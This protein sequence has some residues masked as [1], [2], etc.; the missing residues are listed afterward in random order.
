[1]QRVLPIEI[2]NC[3]FFSGMMMKKQ[4]INVF[5]TIKY[6]QA[7][8]IYLELLIL[9]TSLIFLSTVWDIVLAIYAIEVQTVSPTSKRAKL[10]LVIKWKHKSQNKEFFRSTYP[11]FC[12]TGCVV[13]G[14]AYSQIKRLVNV[15][16]FLLHH[17]KCVVPCILVWNMK[18]F[19][20]KTSQNNS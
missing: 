8:S 11:S 15:Q 1:M 12:S 3:C 10:Q 7:C 13:L 14:L 20:R 17:M 18:K 4:A 9:S 19:G 2:N 5:S 16:L 6:N